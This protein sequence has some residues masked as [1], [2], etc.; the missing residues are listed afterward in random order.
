MKLSHELFPENNKEKDKN[1]SKW[2]TKHECYKALNGNNIKLQ[3][4]Y[5]YQMKVV[6]LHA[7]ER[8][9]NLA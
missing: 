4:R 5:K 8:N 2:L 3:I 9:K 7:W 6:P 1:T